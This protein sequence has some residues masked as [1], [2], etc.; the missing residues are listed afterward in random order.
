[1]P[2]ADKRVRSNGA[3]SG[4]SSWLWHLYVG[5][6]LPLS[7]Y[8]GCVA[9]ERNACKVITNRMLF[10]YFIFFFISNAF[11]HR[12]Y[13]KSWPYTWIQWGKKKTQYFQVHLTAKWRDTDSVVPRW[14]ACCFL[15]QIWCSERQHWRVDN[16]W[17]ERR[18]KQKKKQ[19]M[20]ALA[21]LPFIW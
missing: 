16:C 17:L 19:G 5:K 11:A 15:W 12:V 14:A 21:S 2:Y 20:A 13:C 9:E 4:M 6:G 8:C 10:F 3:V 7:L 18:K 1:M